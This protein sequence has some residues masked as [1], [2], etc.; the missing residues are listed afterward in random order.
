MSISSK[1]LNIVE[2]PYK[3][4]STDDDLLDAINGD[5][6]DDEKFSHLEGQTAEQL[7]EQFTQFPVVYVIHDD[8]KEKA[9][10]YD[11]PIYEQYTVYVGETN[12]IQSRTNQH[13]VSDVKS[14]EKKNLADEDRKWLNFK[15]SK[16]VKQLIIS[17]PHFNKSLTL[18]VENRLI[19]HLVSTDSVKTV[20][21]RGNPQGNY[22]TADEFDKI[23]TQIWRGLHS[24]DSKLFP[25][26]GLIRDSAVFKASPFHTLTREQLVAEN[27]ILNRIS[28]ALASDSD[29]PHI[30]FVQGAAGTGKTVLLSHMFNKILTD[31][32]DS[33]NGLTAHFI[34]NHDQQETIY[35]QILNRLGRDPELAS[36]SIRFLNEHSG[37]KDDS[38][39]RADPNKPINP[40]DIV[41]IDEAHLLL[42]N[43]NQG[44]SGKNQLFDIARRARVVVAVFDPAQILES[45]QQWDEAT[46]NAFFP[47][48]IENGEREAELQGSKYLLSN[49]VLTN[50][51]RMDAPPEILEWINAFVT[52]KELG[53]IPTDTRTSKKNDFVPYTIEIADSPIELFNSIR[54]LNNR[55][56]HTDK[57]LSRGL[58]RTI[59]TYDWDFAGAK[60]CPDLPDENNGK[61]NV[62]MYE[63]NSEWEYC[64]SLLDIPSDAENTFIQPWNYQQAKGKETKRG[65][66]KQKFCW[67]EDP[68]NE[69]EI[70]STYSIQGFDLNYVGVILG[71]SV[72][73]DEENQCVRLDPSK[74]KYMDATDK[75]HFE[76]G[77]RVDF[78]MK[79]LRNQ[80]NVLMTRGVHGMKI[81]AVDKRLQEKLKELSTF[82]ANSK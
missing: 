69:N 79:N 41:T 40:T 3:E 48:K 17:H 61:W 10:N 21:G 82:I 35:K 18:D 73:W 53:P 50:Q 72:T 28:D 45:R 38:P 34:V 16:N 64:K 76:N 1:Q 68:N 39:K 77:K 56:D 81:F 14:E 54:E 5:L 11:H 24:R 43:G 29:Q 23:F 33:N 66:R 49:V 59:A 31:I 55:E 22:Y 27:E 58:S 30:I 67:A 4:Y 36:K 13:V 74:S 25:A 2:V 6:P 65:R 70:G 62:I 47:A 42:T 80:L 71:P 63:R 51:M 26:E 78:S 12:G 19:Q 7:K 20:N 57:A 46:M 60:D 37:K 15:K 9:K 52:G 8:P 32:D 44:W 75:R